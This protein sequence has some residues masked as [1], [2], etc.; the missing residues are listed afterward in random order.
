MVATIGVAAISLTAQEG[1]TEIA[2]LIVQK[3][4]NVLRIQDGKDCIPLVLAA[5]NG[6]EVPG[7]KKI[8][9]KKV[10][11]VQALEL[12][13]IIC[14][15]ISKLNVQQLK[16]ARAYDVIIRTAKFGIIEYFKELTDSSPHL[17]FSVD[18]T[19]KSVGLFQV[20][21]LNKQDKIYN[22]ISQMGQK[23]NRG[24]VISES[25][26]NMLHLA[27]F[28]APPS[29]LDKVSGAALQMQRETQWFQV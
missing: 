1:S 8:Y 12:L 26:N 14:L 22:F 24:H 17:I 25:G 6:N 23:N 5:I 29:Q 28:L 10:I 21:V 20:A 18:V 27:G 7:V 2:K 3:N 19:N 4:I 9:E 13:R 15:Q 16:E 11:H